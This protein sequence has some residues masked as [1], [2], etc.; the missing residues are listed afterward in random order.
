MTK[1]ASTVKKDLFS[2]QKM[3]L[4]IY[5][6]KKVSNPVFGTNIILSFIQEIIS[7]PKKYTGEHKGR[8]CGQS[9]TLWTNPDLTLQCVQNF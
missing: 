9:M 8:S 1:S 3:D 2:V 7:F 5:L 4:L 6:I